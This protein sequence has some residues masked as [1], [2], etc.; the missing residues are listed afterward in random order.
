VSTD[1]LKALIRRPTAIEPTIDHMKTDGKLVRTWLK[2]SLDEAMHGV[3]H[4]DIACCSSK[5]LPS[6]TIESNP[7]P[8][9]P[10]WC[11]QWPSRATAVA[12]SMCTRFF[13]GLSKCETN[14]ARICS[15]TSYFVAPEE[16]LISIDRPPQA[17]RFQIIN[18][19]PQVMPGAAYHRL[20]LKESVTFPN[21]VAL[22]P[23]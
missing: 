5:C 19:W 16:Y 23:C 7:A 4:R 12:S 17:R 15:R 10:G 11:G 6:V 22:V 9:S 1:G 18:D 14:H 20:V 13:E 21:T 3:L 8:E 2:W